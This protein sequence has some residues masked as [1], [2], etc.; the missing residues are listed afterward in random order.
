V[1]QREELEALRA[2]VEEMEST[3]G[4]GEKAKKTNG[5]DG[6]DDW[7][8][9]G[10][11]EGDADKKGEA[12][13]EAS[14]ALDEVRGELV[15]AK[16]ARRMLEEFVSQ[17]REELLVANTHLTSYKS[18]VDTLKVELAQATFDNRSI[19][20]SHEEDMARTALQCKELQ[21]E[22]HELKSWLAAAAATTT[23]ATTDDEED[24]GEKKGEDEG[25]TEGDEGDEGEESEDD[26]G[27]GTVVASSPKFELDVNAGLG[28]EQLA[29]LPRAMHVKAARV[30]VL[31][32][33][34][35]LLIQ[36][37]QERDYFITLQAER[38]QIALASPR[39]ESVTPD[40][41]PPP[42]ELP[43]S[44][45]G[46]PDAS[47]TS[48]GHF[49]RQITLPRL[50]DSLPS[51][52][53]PSRSASF[54]Q[55]PRIV[56]NDA[57]PFLAG[58]QGLHSPNRFSLSL[59]PM[60]NMSSASDGG[61]SL[62]ASTTTPAPTP[63]RRD[64]LSTLPEGAHLLGDKLAEALVR[65]KAYEE[66]AEGDENMDENGLLD[67]LRQLRRKNA[68]LAKQLEQGGRQNRGN[69][70]ELALRSPPN[71][72]V[73]PSLSPHMEQEG[74]Q[75]LEIAKYEAEQR[76]DELVVELSE[77]KAKL[78]SVA[79]HRD[80]LLAKSG[81]GIAGTS[82]RNGTDDANVLVAGEDG[83]GADGVDADG[84]EGDDDSN[85]DNSG[86]SGRRTPA[87]MIEELRA[88]LL[89]T[90][91]AFNEAQSRVRQLEARIAMP[92]PSDESMLAE[93]KA[94]RAHIEKLDTQL[95][96]A[97]EVGGDGDGASTS[98]RLEKENV[99]LYARLISENKE[100]RKLVVRAAKRFAG[101]ND[102]FEIPSPVRADDDEDGDA[103]EGTPA[104]AARL[105]V[106]LDALVA[107]AKLGGPLV[108][109][110]SLAAGGRELSY[111]GV[112]TQ[113]TMYVL[114]ST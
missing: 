15:R 106:A 95:K 6:W 86:E 11:G 66:E 81:V 46:S 103:D 28:A 96:A 80:E 94:A 5:D 91:A 12:N 72:F 58:S 92:P 45:M 36:G 37:V 89:E 61:D 57:S 16:E 63:Q 50:T 85:D 67:T 38:L 82:P 33:R 39:N 30:D 70:S 83:E 48:F 55:S 20:E 14:S 31:E 10:G 32:N 1:T 54:A 79:A 100:L 111:C 90:T 53:P 29:E 112:L 21:T 13:G 47:L 107:Q 44:P 88:K 7:G 2:Q 35:G 75:Q 24:V 8:A 34:I 42:I 97:E 73:S 102:D 17:G 104:W 62:R 49:E 69:I 110:E 76:A 77:I 68:K 84:G 18:E 22:V 114:P 40:T 65:L 113:L 93:L 99:T 59:T 52:P 4:A 23:T 109:N 19:L 74:G 108:M 105:E 43:Q 26:A 3:A 71:G 101:A 87:H 25:E 56:S 60:R 27:A 98:S 9:E 78:K 51:T 41:R 64:S